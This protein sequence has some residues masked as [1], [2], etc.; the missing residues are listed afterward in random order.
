MIIVPIKEERDE[1]NTEKHVFFDMIIVPELRD[2]A[3]DMINTY[4]SEEKLFEANKVADILVAML[5]KKGL[6]KGTVQQSFIDVLIV[7]ALL[8]NLF[9]DESDWTTLYI[10]RSTIEPIA[11]DGG[12][13][14]QVLDA[15]FQT[16][17]AQLGDDTPVPTSRPQPN[18]P[19]ELFTWAVW[20]AKEY[21]PQI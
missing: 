2:F 1:L 16:I 7:S 13:P 6:L 14:Q 15:I 11:R 19:T 5:K 9:Y 3:A 4:G 12:I 18:T 21:K 20:F 10:A 17:E 8:H